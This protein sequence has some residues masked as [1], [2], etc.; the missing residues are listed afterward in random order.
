MW[1]FVRISVFHILFALL[2]LQCIRWKPD[3]F[4]TGSSSISAP[5]RWAFSHFHSCE[6]AGADAAAWSHAQAIMQYLMLFFNHHGEW[7]GGDRRLRRRHLVEDFAARCSS[8]RMFIIWLAG[9]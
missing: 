7:C 4:S 9:S 5:W 6:H 2:V 3:L 8:A 1:I